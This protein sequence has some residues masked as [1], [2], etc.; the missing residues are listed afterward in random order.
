M[1]REEIDAEDSLYR[2]K[3]A[4]MHRLAERAHNNAARAAY[5]SLE[6]SW[7]SLAQ[8]SGELKERLWSVA[9]GAERHRPDA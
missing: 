3:A 1:D 9:P 7:L 2:L 5:L 4:H 8:R 6:A